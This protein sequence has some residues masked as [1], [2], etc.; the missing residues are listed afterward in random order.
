MGSPAD[1]KV[2]MGNAQV[3]ASMK[4]ENLDYIAKNTRLM[5]R[6]VVTEY[7]NKYVG[8]VSSGRI[9]ADGFREIFNL[10]FP[11][12]PLEKLDFS[13]KNW[14][15]KMTQLLLDSCSF[16]CT[17]SPMVKPPTISPRCSTAEMPTA[18]RSL[19]MTSSR[20]ECTTTPSRGKS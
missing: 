4:P 6:E 3:R 8:A 1:S 18:T 9:E 20:R 12:R 16:F 10:A 17:Y 14:W 19:S 13:S 2:T 5:S 7:F 15:M 11:S